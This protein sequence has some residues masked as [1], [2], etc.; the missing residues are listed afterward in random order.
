M[1]TAFLAFPKPATG[2][3]APVDITDRHFKANPFPLYARL[4]AEQPVYRAK[5]GRQDA[6]LVTRYED[7][8]A[9]LKDDRFSKD[10]R[11][12]RTGAQ[13]SLPRWLPGFLRALQ[14]NMLDLDD[15]DHARLRALVHKAFTPAR[16]EQMQEH[17]QAICDQLLAAVYPQGK[18]DLIGDFALLLPL[19][20]ISDLLG[21][22]VADRQRF[23]RWTKA[24]LRPPS[25]LNSL[26]AL[27]ALAAF[28][29]YLLRLFAERRLHPREDLITALVQAE[30]AGD[31]LS[32]D[33]LLA[34]AFILIVAGHET[35]V[36]LIGSGALALLEHPDQLALLRSNPGLIRSA[37]EEL[38]RFVAP[39]E[40][41]T[42][43]YAREAVT[44]AGVTIPRGALTLAVLA[45]ANRDEHY[46]E[47][48]DQLDITR[49]KNRHLAFGYGI[50]ACVGMPLARLEGQIA[51][52]TLVQRLPNLRLA[53]A[54]DQLRWRA[55]P[56][57]R[58]LE[59]LPIRF[60]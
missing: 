4:R 42:E 30:E 22:P 57:V 31:R 33:E 17:I 19:T 39:V 37:I 53:V 58:G 25:A 32:E 59:A 1:S 14:R 34:M 5:L 49:A 9:L 41:A 16:I 56:N 48:P 12:A 46:F 36:N 26:L 50:H 3:I 18:M 60:D 45:S 10:P 15:P 7:V 13:A 38:L 44:I 43:R 40:Q 35:T 47:R 20:V 29:G 52:N 21:I 8:L 28:T 51:I 11:I 27:P 23:H 2:T 24:V 54:P 6:W 55:T